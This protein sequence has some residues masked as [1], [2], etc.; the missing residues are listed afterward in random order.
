MLLVL[1]SGTTFYALVEGWSVVD[2]LYFSVLTLTTV[3][4]GDLVPTTVASKLFTVGYV[5]F[6]V[7]LLAGSPR[8]LPDTAQLLR[9]RA[10]RLAA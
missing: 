5:L 8:L 4:F 1:A 7:G 3:G 2:A 6:G 10:V 9:P